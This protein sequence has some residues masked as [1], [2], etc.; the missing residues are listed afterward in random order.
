MNLMNMKIIDKDQ[1]LWFRWRG[2]REMKNNDQIIFNKTWLTFPFEYSN[3]IRLFEYSNMNTTSHIRLVEYIL[4][5]QIRMWIKKI[6]S[7][8]RNSRHSP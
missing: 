6:Y 8:I 4:F 1:E 2:L 3:I 5:G 7:I